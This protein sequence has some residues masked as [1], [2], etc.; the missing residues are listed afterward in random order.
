M[1]IYLH[2]PTT[3]AAV[4][5]LQCY[6][7]GFLNDVL[8]DKGEEENLTDYPTAERVLYRPTVS[9]QK[10]HMASALIDGLI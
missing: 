10:F 1:M 2:C 9:E 6:F 8:V 3:N 5:L 7:A 4:Q